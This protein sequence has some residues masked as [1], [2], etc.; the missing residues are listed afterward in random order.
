M[1]KLL[2]ILA[3]VAMLS[4]A[5]CGKKEVTTE[6]NVVP[7]ASENVAPATPEASTEEVT[8]VMEETLAPATP[9]ASTEEVST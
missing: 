3:L 7:A 5:S 4:L 2:T 9:E 6:E 1:K 8:P